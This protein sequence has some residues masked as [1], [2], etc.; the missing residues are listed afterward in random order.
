MRHIAA[1]IERATD[2]TYSVYCEEEI[3]S[4]MGD[5]IEEAKSDM[6]QQMDAYKETA[7]AEGFKYPGYLD[8]GDFTIEYSVDA[9]SLMNYYLSKGWVTLSTLESI[10]GISQ[11]QLWAYTHGTKPRK[12]QAER[13]RSGLRDMARDLDTIFA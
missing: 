12:A 3:F 7:K 2:G 1:I 10:T 8:D 5:T 9:L 6:L 13:I 11:K 4:G